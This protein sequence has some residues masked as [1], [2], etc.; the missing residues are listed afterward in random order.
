MMMLDVAVALVA[1]VGVYLVNRAYAPHVSWRN[2]Q[3][4]DYL[5]IAIGVL[6]NA[7][8]IRIVYWDVYWI[9]KGG[10]MSNPSF[11]IFINL[12]VIVAEI[13]ALKARLMMIPEYHRDRFNVLTCAFYPRSCVILFGKDDSL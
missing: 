10:I 9:L 4:S 5:A 2:P 6:L 3:P 7:C 11:N 13:T 8:M 1:I 12:A